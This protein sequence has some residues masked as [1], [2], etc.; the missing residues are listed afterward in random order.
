MDWRYLRKAAWLDTR[1][2]FVNQVPRR[3]ALLDLGSS[4]GETL[5]HFRELRPDLRFYAAD[6]FGAPEKYPNGCEFYCLDLQTDALPW[7]SASMHAITC[8]HLVEHLKTLDNV[9]REAARLLKPGAKLYIETPHPKTVF[10]PSTEGG[11]FTLNFFDD[12]THVEPVT[13]R[14]LAQ[15]SER[16]GL[17]V[18]RMGVSRNLL[19][20][21]AYPLLRFSRPSRKRYTAQVH[22]LGWSIYLVAER[23]A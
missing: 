20:A 19:F 13:P 18:A 15:H 8:M 7:S 23:I 21:A 6:L 2:R 16:A 3:G 14:A 5:C 1:A 17:K 10:L 11:E 12:L 9:F 4:D 22:W